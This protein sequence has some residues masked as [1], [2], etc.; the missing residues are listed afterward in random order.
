M[1]DGEWQMANAVFIWVHSSVHLGPSVVEPA[2]YGLGA[3]DLQF[4]FCGNRLSIP[5]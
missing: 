3:F 4:A 5:L 1:E 2:C